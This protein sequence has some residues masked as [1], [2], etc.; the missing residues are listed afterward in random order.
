[1]G[2]GSGGG[3]RGIKVSYGGARGTTRMSIAGKAFTL[4]KSGGSVTFTAAGGVLSIQKDRG[5]WSLWSGNRR[6][7]GGSTVRAIRSTLEIN[8][9]LQVERL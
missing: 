6:L 1:M 8:S 7:G 5:T 3:G 9:G 4:P 2:K